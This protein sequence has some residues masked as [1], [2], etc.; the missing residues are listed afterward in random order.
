[1]TIEAQTR[2]YTQDDLRDL[3]ARP[4]NADKFFELIEGVIVEVAGTSAK[5]TTIAARISFYL[6][7]HVLPLNL[8]WITSADGRFELGSIDN[9]IPDTAFVSRAR[10]PQL[11]DGSFTIAP[12]L[13]VE[14][15]SPSDNLR[16]VQRKAKRYLILGSTVVWVVY[17]DD[18]AVEV[19]RL[20]PDGNVSLQEVEV[21]GT[22]ELPDLLP[23]FSLPVSKVFPK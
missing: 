9:L 18:Q 3:E 15:V 11:P 16:A 20:L 14:V 22:L 13:A 6:N 8:G 1:M 2:L 12:D 10:Q 19:Y 23:G 5:P 21:T 17:P 4:E 7:A